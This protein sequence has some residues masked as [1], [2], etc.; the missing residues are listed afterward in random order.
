MVLLWVSV[1]MP[2]LADAQF[3]YGDQ[4]R[5]CIRGWATKFEMGGTT[6]GDAA[7][8]ASALSERTGPNDGGSA[9]DYGAAVEMKNGIRSST[10]RIPPGIRGNFARLPG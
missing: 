8:F 2:A 9:G 10:G 5:W 3:L 7:I 6:C 4:F 1:V